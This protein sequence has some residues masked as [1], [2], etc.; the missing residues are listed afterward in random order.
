METLTFPHVEA[1]RSTAHVALFTKVQKSAA[2]RKRIIAAAT[3]EG[4]EGED[5][6]DVVNFAFIDARLITS[7]LH[8]QTAICQAILAESQGS[9]RT[10]TIHSEILWVLNP[11]NSI[12][13]AIRRYGVSDVNSSLL[14]V[15][16][17]ESDIPAAQVEEKMKAIVM[18]NITPLSELNAVTDWAMVKKYNKLNDE[19]AIRNAQGDDTR[20]H[21]AV[22]N[23]VVS[24]VA[25]KSVM[26]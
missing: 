2:L 17:G 22:D 14:V 5:E 20:E 11:T 24:T 23:I 7:W 19:L 10:K 21:I 12:T 15:R 6:R 8:L 26:A 4:R 25:M 9:L 13:E 3:L 1:E 18:G 16:I